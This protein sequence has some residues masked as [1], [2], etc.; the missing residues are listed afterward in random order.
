MLMS[1][2]PIAKEFKSMSISK[3]PV[4]RDAQLC[5]TKNTTHAHHAYLHV[6]LRVQAAAVGA[7][8]D[9]VGDWLGVADARPCV[10]S[11]AEVDQ[12]EPHQDEVQVGQLS[13]HI[14]N[15]LIRGFPYWN[16]CRGIKLLSQVKHNNIEGSAS[17][18]ELMPCIEIWMA[19]KVPNIYLNIWKNGII[20]VNRI[21]WRDLHQEVFN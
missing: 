7:D 6:S 8:D 13:L 19:T 10:V 16:N 18:K 9:N 14:L 5:H 21:I 12:V 4:R 15:V 17:K 2:I 3:I 1:N 20:S 11:V